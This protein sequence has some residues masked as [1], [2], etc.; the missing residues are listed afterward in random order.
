M[1]LQRPLLDLALLPVSQQQ[2]HSPAPVRLLFREAPPQAAPAIKQTIGNYT[3]YG[4][5]TEATNVRA[6]SSAVY[7]NYAAMTLE[8]CFGDC[9]GAGYKYWGVEYAGECYCAGSVAAPGGNADCSF[10]CPRNPL[11][12]CGAGNRLSTYVYTGS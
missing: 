6:L 8:M 1:Y 4:C 9:A 2:S 12:F 10:T 11:E 5:Q 3:Y 7:Y